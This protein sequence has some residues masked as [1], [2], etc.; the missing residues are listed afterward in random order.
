MVSLVGCLL[1][2]TVE[3][4]RGLRTPP[5]VTPRNLARLPHAAQRTVAEP[6]A[7]VEERARGRLRGWRTRWRDEPGDVR[8][9]SAE[10]GHLHE[11]GQP[12]VPPERCSA[13]SSRSRSGSCSA[14]RARSSCCPAAASSATPASSA[15]T[16]SAP[17]CA[18]TAR[19]C[20]RSACA[21]TTSRPPTRRTAQPASFTA[22]IGF[23]TAAD[24]A[25][26]TATWRQATLAV[27]HPLRTDGSRALPARARLRPALHGHLSGR[28]AADG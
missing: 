16:P 28:S 13:C 27:N 23:Q 14:T 11:I 19:T 12:R 26:G 3:Q 6:V 4:L 17:A 15:T 8:T 24:V 20:S 1:P 5:V 25:A 7:D 2:R 22:A 18:W 9:V 10:R 21:S